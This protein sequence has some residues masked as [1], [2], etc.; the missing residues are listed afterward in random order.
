MSMSALLGSRWSWLDDPHAIGL[1]RVQPF[2]FYTPGRGF[3]EPGALAKLAAKRKVALARS[4]FGTSPLCGTE[5]ACR[6]ELA[7]LKPGW[8]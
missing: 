6:A 3:P 7:R 5:A 4:S 2:Y 8:S 1:E